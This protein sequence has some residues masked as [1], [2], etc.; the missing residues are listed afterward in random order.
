MVDH[1]HGMHRKQE[2]SETRVFMSGQWHFHAAMM[3]LCGRDTP[4]SPCSLKYL[5]AGFSRKFINLSVLDYPP[6]ML[7][8]GIMLARVLWHPR[9]EA[10]TKVRSESE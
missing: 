8:M 3:E 9:M 7:P 1:L 5:P 2:Q 4:D 10:G 6:Y